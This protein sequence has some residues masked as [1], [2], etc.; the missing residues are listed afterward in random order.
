[1]LVSTG[2]SLIISSWVMSLIFLTG[3]TMHEGV[4]MTSRGCQDWQIP[5]QDKG[6]CMLQLNM[7][8]VRIVVVMFVDFV[9]SIGKTSVNQFEWRSSRG[10][11]VPATLHQLIN[12][13]WSFLWIR[14][15]VTILDELYNL[16]MSHA[17]VR[18]HSK[19]KNFPQDYSKSP[20]IRFN[21]EFWMNDGIERHPSNRDC[22][23]LVSFVII[24]LIQVLWE[25]KV[26]YFDYHFIID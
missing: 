13:S 10:F 17:I 14:K 25:T 2:G 20:D 1:M 16:L 6:R 9:V 3:V 4:R 18:L 7:N 24:V 21:R 11:P 5:D 8:M 12:G 19:G 15:C 23:S 26:C 22:I